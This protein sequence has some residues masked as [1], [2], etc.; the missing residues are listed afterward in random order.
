MHSAATRRLATATTTASAQSQ[1]K[2]HHGEIP[3]AKW[4]LAYE[5]EKQKKPELKRG[6]EQ[7][8]SQE[9]LA[10]QETQ[11]AVTP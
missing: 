3:P 1:R 5:T 11:G 10:P 7:G 8:Q 2:V 9:L 4:H 6:E